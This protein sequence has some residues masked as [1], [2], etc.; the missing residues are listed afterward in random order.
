MCLAFPTSLL[1]LPMGLLVCPPYRG[2][3]PLGHRLVPAHGLLGTGLYSRGEQ[4]SS[5]WSFLSIYS[6][7]PSLSLPPELHLLQISW[8]TINV[9]QLNQPKSIFYPGSVEKLSSAK[10][11]SHAKELGDRC[12]RLSRVKPVFGAFLVP[13]RVPGTG[14]SLSE[15]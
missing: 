11:V 8:A 4:P 14:W 13:A 2:S 1:V 12:T 15:P 9:M 6:R 10:L 5:E 7:S 3:K